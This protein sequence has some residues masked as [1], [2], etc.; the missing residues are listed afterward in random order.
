MSIG[1]RDAP[2]FRCLMKPG[3]CGRLVNPTHLTSTQLDRDE[4]YSSHGRDDGS[5]DVPHSRHGF[6][7]QL[8]EVIPELSLLQLPLQSQLRAF[9]SRPHVLWAEQLLPRQQL[10]ANLLPFLSKLPVQWVQPVL[11]QL[12][13][14]DLLSPECELR[15]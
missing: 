3:H 2:V 9:V 1:A 10:R 13:P 15:L 6:R 14:D 12:S 7:G 4:I 5:G 8:P 11:S